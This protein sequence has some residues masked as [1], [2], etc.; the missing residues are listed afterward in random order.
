[1]TQ[2]ALQ[3]T[4]GGMRLVYELTPEDYAAWVR[5]HYAKPQ[6]VAATRNSRLF[7]PLFVVLL[8]GLSALAR[9]G[10]SAFDGVLVTFALV[11]YLFFPA[12]LRRNVATRM[13]ALARQ[14]IS[15][16]SV[17]LHE[18]TVDA[19]GLHE[20]H[21]YG[22]RFSYW[23]GIERVEVDATHLF[24]YTGPNAGYIVPTRDIG[25]RDAATLME[26]V[27]ER[28]AEDLQRGQSR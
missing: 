11:W 10:M 14:G 18:M 26:V 21:A 28:M 23:S 7:L 5:H 15:R 9:G 22:G 25:E 19:T 2:P 6:Q 13:A 20:S 8:V 12:W 24:I 3:R 4:S 27:R 16:G 1:M 17:G